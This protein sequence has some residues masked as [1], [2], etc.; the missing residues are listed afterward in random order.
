MESWQHQQ[1]LHKHYPIISAN[2]DY[3]SNDNESKYLMNSVSTKLPLALK[4]APKG[5]K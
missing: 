2:S 5:N 3:L 4:A 1:K